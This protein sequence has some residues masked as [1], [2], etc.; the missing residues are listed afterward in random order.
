MD[1]TTFFVWSL[2]ILILSYLIFA[3][4]SYFLGKLYPETLDLQELKTQELQTQDAK[5]QELKDLETSDRQ[6]RK[7]VGLF[8]LTAMIL[9]MAMTGVNAFMNTRS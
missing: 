2:L 5:T 9:I 1:L 3:G 6:R 7:W 4:I 8:I